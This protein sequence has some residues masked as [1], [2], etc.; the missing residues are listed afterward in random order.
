MGNMGNAAML[1]TK[2]IHPLMGWARRPRLLISPGQTE[3]GSSET[4]HSL[5]KRPEAFK[6]LR[7]GQV[8]P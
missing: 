8:Y 1:T 5:P 6:N 3:K 7:D 4:H 2:A